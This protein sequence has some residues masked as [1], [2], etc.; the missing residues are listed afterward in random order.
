LGEPLRIQVAETTTRIRQT[1]A[2]QRPPLTAS[3]PFEYV[4]L[5]RPFSSQNRTAGY[6]RW[7]TRLDQEVASQV[8]TLSRGR[9]WLPISENVRVLIVWLSAQPD[10]E[11]LPDLDAIIKPL[12]DAMSE[13]EGQRRDNPT[14]KWVIRRDSQ[15]RRLEAVRINL[16]RDGL[17]LPRPIR[18]REDDPEWVQGVLVYVR[19][20]R[21][22]APD[23]PDVNWWK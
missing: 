14:G 15:V 5:G 1:M 3:L 19:V 22:D 23:S 7:R 10:A 17:Q 6:Q 21:L 2:R 11:D 9:G 12:L 8:D 18:E 4:V 16:N 20:E 13:Y